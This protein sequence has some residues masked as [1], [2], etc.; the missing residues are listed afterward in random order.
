M[1]VQWNARSL[2]ANWQEFKGFVQEER[3][4][5]WVRDFLT[6]RKI[7]VKING[8]FSKEYSVENGTPQGSIISPVLFL[9]M[10]N[11]VFKNIERSINVALFADDGAMWKRGR[12]VNHVVGKM[13]PAV[14]VVQKWALELGFRISIDKTK[15]IFFS[16]KKI[17]QE[18]NII[19]TTRRNQT[20]TRDIEVA[21]VYSEHGFRAKEIRY[22]SRTRGK[23]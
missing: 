17:T 15:T 6:G 3:M 12:N 16:R 11:D 1:I 7:I 4:L 21:V 2:I 5:Q 18:L 20:Q 19:R 22:K 14:D 9:I 8:A 10:I 13:Q 23:E